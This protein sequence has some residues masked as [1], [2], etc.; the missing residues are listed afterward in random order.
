MDMKFKLLSLGL[1]IVGFLFIKPV[2]SQNSVTIGSEELNTKAVLRLVA[3]GGDQGFILP[4]VDNKSSINPSTSEKGM[5]IYE[6]TDSTVYFW[7]GAN[8][9][10]V[11]DDQAA[12]EVVFD[13]AISG[14]NATDVQTALD[15]I[16]ANDSS[17]WLSNDD[18][19]EYH[20]GVISVGTEAYPYINP[21]TQGI[22][23]YNPS[24]SDTYKVGFTA[25]IEN[26]SGPKA[27]TSVSI[28]NDESFRATGNSV[29]IEN[30]SDEI[31]QG[32]GVTINGNG[33]GDAVGFNT[34]LST[35]GAGTQTGFST[36]LQKGSGL[37]T[38]IFSTI[39][40][41]SEFSSYGFYNV[42][43]NSS[44]AEAYGTYNQVFGGNGRSIGVY[45]NVA[46]EGEAYGI[47]TE[48]E[49][50][51]FLQG[52]V[53]IGIDASDAKLQV[54]AED[55]NIMDK[56]IKVRSVRTGDI[57]YTGITSEVFGDGSGSKTGYVTNI[58]GNGPK[59]GLGISITDTDSDLSY[60]IFS[61]GEDRNYFSGNV[62]IGTSVPS[63]KLEVNGSI[64]GNSIFLDDWE[65][66]QD[67]LNVLSLSFEGALKGVFLSTSGQYNM[68]S[69]RK[70]KEEIQPLET[71]LAKVSKLQASRYQ[72]KSNNPVKLESIGFIAQ[73]VK[74]LFPELVHSTSDEDQQELLT[75]DYS[76]FGVLAIKAIQEQQE[77]IS[78]QE[79]Q[80]ASQE[81][82]IKALEDQVAFL[83]KQLEK[84]P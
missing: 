39:D 71:V 35:E 56:G 26:G 53:G 49:D 45:A 7:D 5:L 78:E 11:I 34:L 62:G 4:V 40:Q 38:G 29:F 37:K 43:D 31:A 22:R 60:G 80:I 42:V 82:R 13:N 74:P 63:E 41:D 68:T 19:I 65:I 6:N 50:K 64:K 52:S 23:Y 10:D 54:L 1:L 27:G 18:G 47:F 32:A 24:E 73:D 81:A 21:L 76:G 72:Y 70:L 15:E 59:T 46:S 17:I 30:N 57:L 48:G 33:S 28:Y 77:K 25:L 2:Y 66:K 20:D 75:L 67:G 3:P 58:S 36:Y 14:L 79:K 44:S 51:N 55:D 69:D 12:S 9:I 16:V 83:I 8:W 61:N 84:R